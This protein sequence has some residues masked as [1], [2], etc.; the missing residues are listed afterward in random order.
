M[1]AS[2]AA[3]RVLQCVCSYCNMCASRAAARVCASLPTPTAICVHRALQGD[4]QYARTLWN[5]VDNRSY[6][7]IRVISVSSARE[8]S[9]KSYPSHPL[10][11]TYP[12]WMPPLL[13]PLTSG[14]TLLIGDG[15]WGVWGNSVGG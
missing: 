14:D 4:Q 12:R 10:K 1:C 15:V 5:T 6:N 11:D 8:A 9:V 13:Y 2:R 7:R 3:A